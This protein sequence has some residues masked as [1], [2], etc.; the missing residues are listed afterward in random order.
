[1]DFSK[2]DQGQT[3]VKVHHKPGGASNFSLAHDDGAA[4]DR[5]GN[6]NKIGAKNNTAQAQVAATA[7][8]VNQAKKNQHTTESPFATDSTPQQA[9]T[10]VKY[11][12]NPPG[13]RSNFTLG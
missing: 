10:S 3:S 1:M 9:F 8:P 2:H 13:G 6:S 12:G 4:D 5:W 11:S 7:E